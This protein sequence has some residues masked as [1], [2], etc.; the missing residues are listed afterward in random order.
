MD[1]IFEF[2][3]IFCLVSLH[4]QVLHWLLLSA[5]LLELVDL[6]KRLKVTRY[7][8]SIKVYAPLLQ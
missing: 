6:K 1:T 2:V 5:I 7:G 3:D 4:Q 8:R